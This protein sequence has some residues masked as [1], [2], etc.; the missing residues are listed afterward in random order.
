MNTVNISLTANQVKLVDSLTESLSFANRSE[1]FRAL[2]RLVERKPEVLEVSVENFFQAPSTRSTN[3]IVNDMRDTGKY[4]ERFLKSIE[5]G[6]L[7]SG[8]FTK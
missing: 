1:F 4:N 3:K 5:K 8:Y 6:L 2:V 7:R